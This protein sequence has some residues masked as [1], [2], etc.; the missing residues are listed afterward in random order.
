VLNKLLSAAVL[1]SS[2]HLPL[3]PERLAHP[4]LLF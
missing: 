3:L 2:Q 4:V 1:Y